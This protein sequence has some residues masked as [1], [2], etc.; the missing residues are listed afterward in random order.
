MTDYCQ[1]GWPVILPGHDTSNTPSADPRLRL[2]VIPGANRRIW[3]RD[4]AAGFV[5]AHFCLWFHER[6]QPLD[7]D[8]QYDDWGYAYR[9]I[10]GSSDWSNHAGGL[11]VDLNALKHPQGRR[12][13]FVHH[14]KERR[15]R[16]RLARLYQH[17][18]RW[19]GEYE[20][21]PDEMHYEVIGSLASMRILARTL[22]NTPRGKRIIEANP[23]LRKVL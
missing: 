19:G 11:A 6:I 2:Y 9:P 8:K 23:G 4:G 20:R 15:I 17:L 10:N 14:W 7:K 21:V 18:I 22:A 3:L 1:N 16:R 12:Q 5:L 13:T